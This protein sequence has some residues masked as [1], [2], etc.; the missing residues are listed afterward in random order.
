MFLQ[1]LAPTHF[2]NNLTELCSYHT[3][4]A[5]LITYKPVLFLWFYDKNTYTCKSK[6]RAYVT[7]VPYPVR[8]YFFPTEHRY[9]NSIPSFL[10][11]RLD[12][13]VPFLC[14]VLPPVGGMLATTWLLIALKNLFPSLR[15]MVAGG[16]C[17]ILLLL[18]KMT[19]KERSKLEWCFLCS[20]FFSF[21][22]LI[23]SQTAFCIFSI[24]LWT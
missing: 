1:S 23:C 5:H 10:V 11:H 22:L 4:T 7:W 19:S 20:F 12:I 15:G 2:F 9:Q 14:Y 21:C 6:E 16:C 18:L 13:W 8:L 17:R 24:L 3:K